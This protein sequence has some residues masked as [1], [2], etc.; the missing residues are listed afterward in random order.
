MAYPIDHKNDTIKAI[1]SS[2]P[3]EN[4]ELLRD[5][6]HIV[7]DGQAT[8]NGKDECKNLLQILE[9]KGIVTKKELY[10]RFLKEG[11]NKTDGDI[12]QFLADWLLPPHG[13]NHQLYTHK[14][15]DYDYSQ[16][17]DKDYWSAIEINQSWKVKKY[18]LIKALGKIYSLSESRAEALAVLLY[19]VHRLRDIQCNNYDEK[20]AE[21][22][23]YLFNAGNEIEKYVIPLIA[24]RDMKNKLQYLINGVKNIEQKLAGAVNEDF[25][26]GLNVPIDK[27]IGSIDSSNGGYI[28]EVLLILSDMP[29][30][31]C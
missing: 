18:L 27:L 12:D 3:K 7:I 13:P 9:N 1:G 24:D 16:E 14:G 30:S 6:V 4:A 26:Q 10:D 29:L 25:W 15:W 28:T 2:T 8:T 11:V 17:E 23:K 31:L 5:L 22:K 19:N 20:T 21:K